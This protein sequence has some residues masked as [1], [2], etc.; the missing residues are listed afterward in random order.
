M[1]EQQLQPIWVAE[2]IDTD[3]GKEKRRKYM[4]EWKRRKYAENPEIIKNF[5]KTA[6]YKTKY[7]GNK[8]DVMKYGEMFP[9]VSK[10]TSSLEELRELDVELFRDI[11]RRYSFEVLVRDPL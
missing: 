9:V 7:K 3:E 1:S 2:G 11:I 6:Y 10:I 4:R 8:E 5:N